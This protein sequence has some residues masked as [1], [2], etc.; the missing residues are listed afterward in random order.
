M[1]LGAGIFLLA[2]GA[3]LAFAVNVEVPG[4]DLTVV[5]YIL[6]VAGAVGIILGIV[7]LSRKRRSVSESRSIVDPATGESVRRDIRDDRL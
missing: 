3:I 7:L 6:M 2:V 4:I 1:S 5:G